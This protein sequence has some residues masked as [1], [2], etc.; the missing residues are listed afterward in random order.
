MS[1]S[2]RPNKADGSDGVT[3]FTSLLYNASVFC[4]REKSEKHLRNDALSKSSAF[5]DDDF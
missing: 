1:A 2:R 3:L 5:L 4:I